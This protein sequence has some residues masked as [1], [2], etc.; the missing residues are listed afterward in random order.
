LRERKENRERGRKRVRERGRQEKREE[1]RE[2]GGKEGAGSGNFN[3]S[4]VTARRYALQSVRPQFIIADFR[5]QSKC[6]YN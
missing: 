4:R 2:E 5:Q 1:K 6:P 3:R